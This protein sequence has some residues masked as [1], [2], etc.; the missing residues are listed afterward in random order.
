MRKYFLLSA[1]A[2]LATSTA[3]ATTDYA[4]VTAKAT[5]EVAG[6]LTCS[7]IDFGT[8]VVKQNN[9]DSTVIME[10]SSWDNTSEISTTG[11]ILSVDGATSSVCDEFPGGYHFSDAVGVDYPSTIELFAAGKTKTLTLDLS[12]DDNWG[13]GG[14]LHIPSKIEAGDY[15][16]TFTLTVITNS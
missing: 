16:G 6:T 8:I 3:N 2:L 14:T 15:V 11:D 7:N 1:V 9:G 10:A 12:D 4:E 13:M 5:I